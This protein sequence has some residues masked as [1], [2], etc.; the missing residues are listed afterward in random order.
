MASSPKSRSERKRGGVLTAFA[1]FAVFAVPTVFVK[2]PITVGV[3]TAAVVRPT[4]R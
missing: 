1:V 2:F 4:K 3:S